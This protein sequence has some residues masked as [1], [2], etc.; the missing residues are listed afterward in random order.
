MKLKMKRSI[1]YN[2]NKKE[3]L[4]DIKLDIKGYFYNYTHTEISNDR[5]VRYLDFIKTPTYHILSINLWVYCYE[6]L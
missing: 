6:I 2:L 3:L 4:R 5:K 1:C